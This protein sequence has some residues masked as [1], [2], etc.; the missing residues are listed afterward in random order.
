MD[1][2]DAFIELTKFQALAYENKL[3]YW[4][5]NN[6]AFFYD[7]HFINEDVVLHLRPENLLDRISYCKWVVGHWRRDHLENQ[8]SF[9]SGFLFKAFEEYVKTYEDQIRNQGKANVL[10]REIPR[11]M[12][13]IV[14]LKLKSFLLKLVYE[15]VSTSTEGDLYR[16]K[17]TPPEI[18][19]RLKGIGRALDIVRYLVFLK[20]E[21]AKLEKKGS[22]G[23]N[24]VLL[25]KYKGRLFTSH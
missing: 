14:S 9:A 16:Y 17:V 20:R 1:S 13:A 25:L 11:I 21:R 19:T 7:V 18:F 2:D 15:H 10:E 8:S 12:K 4:D 22:Q 3:R 6:I 23:L 24:L 5:N